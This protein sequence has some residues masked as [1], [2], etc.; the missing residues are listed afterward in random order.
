MCK[1]APQA[2]KSNH[3]GLGCQHLSIF[4]FFSFHIHNILGVRWKSEALQKEK[5][6]E[7]VCKNAPQVTNQPFRARMGIK[8][9]LF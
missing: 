5:L 1:N 6:T 2:T 4:S 9:T 8:Q 3:L 7:V